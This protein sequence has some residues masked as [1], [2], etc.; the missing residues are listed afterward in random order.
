MIARARPLT[1]HAFAL[2]MLAIGLDGL[3][4][5]LGSIEDWVAQ[6][7]RDYPDFAWD[8]DAVIVLLSARFT[9]VCIPIAA[10]WVFANPFAR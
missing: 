2:I 4:E 9:I 8:E 1:I 5:G 3:I 6:M 7:T 10:I